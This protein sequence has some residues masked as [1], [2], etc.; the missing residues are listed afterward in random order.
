MLIVADSG[1]PSVVEYV[2]RSE[3]G[4]GREEGGR[5]GGG[6]ESELGPLSPSGDVAVVGDVVVE[7]RRRR[8]GQQVLP[9]GEP[10]GGPRLR[11]GPARPLGPRYL[12]P[13]RERLSPPGHLPRVL[14][15][16]G[17]PARHL[18]GANRLLQV[19]RT[20]ALRYLHQWEPPRRGP[21]G[22]LYPDR[23]LLHRPQRGTDLHPARSGR[24][25]NC[26]EVLW[27]S[28]YLLRDQ[29]L[30]PALPL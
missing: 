6:S 7:C 23:L 1:G 16:Q 13:R 29:R 30:L 12:Q 27:P 18:P 26:P 22:A 10:A 3:E 25:D 14:G 17:V 9:R 19:G 11:P 15:L 20:P 5:K 21:T 4:R 2:M 8:V 24:E 28:R